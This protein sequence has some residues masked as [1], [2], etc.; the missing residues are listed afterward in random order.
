M[1][2]LER[3]ATPWPIEAKRLGSRGDGGGCGSHLHVGRRR[4]I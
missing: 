4:R 1:T 2:T 3:D